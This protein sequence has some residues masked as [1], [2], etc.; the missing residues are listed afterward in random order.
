MSKYPL[1]YFITFT[2]YG[3]WLHGDPRGSFMKSPDGA[4][5]LDYD[6]LSSTS[7]KASS[8]I[9]RSS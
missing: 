9:R 3:T 8:S 7:A 1:A 2:T 6:P 4:E 5:H